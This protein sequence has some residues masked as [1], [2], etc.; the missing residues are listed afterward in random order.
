VLDSRC[1]FCTANLDKPE[2]GSLI[3]ELAALKTIKRHVRIDKNTPIWR[4]ATHIGE[5]R[6]TA[7]FFPEGWLLQ[8][9]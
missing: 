3:R 1:Q 8:D 9:I 6:D 7:K 4:Y 5:K 2:K